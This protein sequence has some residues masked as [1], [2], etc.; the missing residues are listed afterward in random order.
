MNRYPEYVS[1]GFIDKNA[2]IPAGQDCLHSIIKNYWDINNNFCLEGS[3]RWL[4]YK[5]KIIEHLL[6]NSEKP[7]K[8]QFYLFN[9]QLK[10]IDEIKLAVTNYIDYCSYCSNKKLYYTDILLKLTFTEFDGGTLL[11]LKT[12]QLHILASGFQLPNI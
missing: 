9:I 8:V 11:L 3:S 1:I 2:I 12:K 10:N 4:L 6:I 7:E 5:L